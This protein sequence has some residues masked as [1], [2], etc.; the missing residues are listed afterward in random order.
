MKKIIALSILAVA[1]AIVQAQGTIE[2]YSISATYASYT[3]TAVSSYV[4]GNQT[5]G[6]SGKAALPPTGTASYY[7]YALLAGSL[8]TSLAGTAPS[9]SYLE[10]LSVAVSGIT[11]FYVA[12][13]LA[14]PGHNVG[15]PVQIG[16]WAAPANSYTDGTGVEMNY[17]LV[18]W[19]SSLG[20][21]WSTIESDL[22]NDTWGAGGY[23]GAST[24]G[25]G[26]V[27]GG[28]NSLSAP[29]IFGVSTAEPGG[30]AAGPTL[31][32]IPPVPEPTTLALSALGGLSLLAFRRKKA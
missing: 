20:S 28:A 19:S 22:A 13:G 3:N 7:D 10:G 25:Y 8:N 26:Y 14:G 9:A 32:D 31:Y 21:S 17:V 18:G 15:A 12:G 5:G 27:G 4:S 29:S 11:N 24:I 6:T 16:S 2:V 1:P 30:L 23:F